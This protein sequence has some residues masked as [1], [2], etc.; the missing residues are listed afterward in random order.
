MRGVIRLGDPTS[1]G[2]RVV[3]T[4]SRSIVTGRPVA[5]VGDL[6]VCPRKGHSV[7]VIAE[8]DPA[9]RLDGKPVAFDGH[10]TSCG[11][12]LISTVASSGRAG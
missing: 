5:V 7:C 12:T 11:A 6:C 9:V 8:G 10:K 1:H 3:A 2:G 4:G